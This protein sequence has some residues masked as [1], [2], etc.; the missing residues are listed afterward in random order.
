MAAALQVV[1]TAVA[2]VILFNL[3]AWF[4]GYFDWAHVISWVFLP[5]AVRLLG[6]M[7]LGVRGAAGV[8]LGTLWTN[9]AVFGNHLGVSL[10]VATLSAMGPLIAVHL[11][12]RILRVPLD[13]QGLTS[14]QLTVF[15]LMGALCNVIPHNLFFWSAGLASSPGSLGAMFVGDLVGTVLVLYSLRGLLLMLERLAKNPTG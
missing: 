3:N 5:A 4:F 7:A 6:V 15:A 14:G 8:F 1:G 9:D 10:F 13:L 11:S 2:W 12:A